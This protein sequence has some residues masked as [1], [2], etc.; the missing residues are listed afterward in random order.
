MFIA[1]KVPAFLRKIL[2]ADALILEEESWNAFPYTKTIY[3]NVWMKKDFYLTIESMHAPG[4][5]TQQN[6]CKIFK[7]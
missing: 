2:P 7:F 4:L 5:G 3:T 6:V 1:S